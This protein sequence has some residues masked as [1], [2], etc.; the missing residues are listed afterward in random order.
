MTTPALSDVF[1]FFDTNLY[2]TLRTGHIIGLRNREL[3]VRI[4]PLAGYYVLQK[5]YSHLAMP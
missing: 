2:R 1:V 5:L 3:E 4:T